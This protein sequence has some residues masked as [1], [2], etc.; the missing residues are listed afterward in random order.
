LFLVGYISEELL[1]SESTFSYFPD[2]PV[3]GEKRKL[4]TVETRAMFKDNLEVLVN[5]LRGRMYHVLRATAS[6]AGGRKQLT[7]YTRPRLEQIVAVLCTYIWC[8]IKVNLVC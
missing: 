1:S 6:W 3:L 2:V 5:Y 4:E 7:I 8:A